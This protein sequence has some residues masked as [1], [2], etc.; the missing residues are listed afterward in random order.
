MIIVVDDDAGMRRAL[1]RLLRSAGFVVTTFDDAE[2]L[3]RA[4]VAADAACF[5]FDV[6]LPGISG[7]ELSQK[8]AESGTR[9]PLIFITAH[10][11]PAARRQAERLGSVAYLA[12]PF[13]G[14]RLLDA[15]GQVLGDEPQGSRSD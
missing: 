6:R 5:V 14:R 9:R 4:N 7:F 3:L 10:D 11:E 2:A 8:L 1:E 13:P 12:K 15:I